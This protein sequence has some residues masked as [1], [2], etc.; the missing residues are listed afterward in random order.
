MASMEAYEND[1]RKLRRSRKR[2]RYIKNAVTVGVF[3]VIVMAIY[4]SRSLWLPELEGVLQRNFIT[5]GNQEERVES[6]PIDISRKVNVLI[7]PMSDCL[8]IYQDNYLTTLDSG[9]EELFSS[10]LTYGSP[11]I[12]TEGK[13]ALAYDMGGYSFTVITKKSEAFSHRLDDQ[14][15]YAALGDRG[16]AA[17]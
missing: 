10:Y 9:G 5:G 3:I 15:L 17:G 8:A 16:G 4:L 11:V 1:M 12:L 14:I 13:R 6:F 7:A 2:K